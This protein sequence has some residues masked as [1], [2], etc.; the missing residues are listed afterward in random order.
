MRRLASEQGVTELDWWKG[1]QQKVKEGKIP[2]D[3]VPT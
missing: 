1:W 3:W 2:K